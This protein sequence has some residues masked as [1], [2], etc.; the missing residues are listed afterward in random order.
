MLGIKWMRVCSINVRICG[1]PVRY[2]WHRYVARRNRSSRP[3]T[4]LPC[5]LA[6]YLNSGFTRN[7]IEFD[8]VVLV[9]LIILILK[10]FYIQ[11]TYT[12]LYIFCGKL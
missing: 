2:C 7:E 11:I 8:F 3:K 10:N 6:M 9:N 4:S 12:Y 1:S 5:M